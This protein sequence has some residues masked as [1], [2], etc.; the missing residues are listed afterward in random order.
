MSIQEVDAAIHSLSEKDNLIQCP[1]F[2][3][4]AATRA[5]EV[6]RGADRTAPTT[7]IQYLAWPEARAGEDVHYAIKVSCPNEEAMIYNLTGTNL[8][9]LYL[10]PAYRA[11][12]F[13]Q[14]MFPVP[15]VI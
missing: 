1:N 5:M 14:R 2:C 12:G 7:E 6:A 8:F 10:G 4:Y 9:P 11:I 3:R 13:L 15:E